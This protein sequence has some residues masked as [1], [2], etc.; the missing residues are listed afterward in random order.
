MKRAARLRVRR[1][2]KPLQ[3]FLRLDYRKL[4]ALLEDAPSLAAAIG[5]STVPHFSTFQKAA[6]RLLRAKHARRLLDETVQAAQTGV[7]IGSE[8]AALLGLL[9]RTIVVAA[10]R[11]CGDSGR[12][13]VGEAAGDERP[14]GVA[15]LQLHRALP[16]EPGVTTAA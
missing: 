14:F 2:I 9:P 8:E 11:Q 3:E 5:L 4:S 1:L 7:E 12:A 15:R 16:A 6:A 10:D 13:Q